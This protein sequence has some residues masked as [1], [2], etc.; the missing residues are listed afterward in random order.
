MEN[1]SQR[2]VVVC[3]SRHFKDP[4]SA[5]AAIV[6]R[7]NELDLGM[8]VIHGD[9]SGAD[10]IAGKAAEKRGMTVLKFPADWTTHEPDCRCRGNSWCQ[11]AGKRRNLQM[12]DEQPELVIAF[13]NGY[14]S[15]TKHT[16]RHAINRD[17][18]LEVIRLD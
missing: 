5:T 15:G 10:R 12:L 3:G 13:H 6:R 14:S 2:K 16:I 8:T 4:L 9:A 1:L 7:I 18:P 17:I 11:E